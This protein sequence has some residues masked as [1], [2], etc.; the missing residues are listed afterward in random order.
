LPPPSLLPFFLP[1]FLPLFCSLNWG[2]NPGLCT[3]KVG[4]QPF[5]PCLQSILLWLYFRDGCL[6][7]YLPRI[8]LNCDRLD[9]SLPIS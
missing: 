9:L 6:M 4:T 1:S 7:N 3:C 5:E 2:L 8:A